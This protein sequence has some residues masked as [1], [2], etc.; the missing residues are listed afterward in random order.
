MD[1]STPLRYIGEY[2]LVYPKALET[3]MEIYL[4]YIQTILY[5]TNHLT[6]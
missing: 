6:I 1:P 3:T 5:I 4:I 2:V